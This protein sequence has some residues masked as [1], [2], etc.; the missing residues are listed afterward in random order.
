M[1][2]RYFLAEEPNKIYGRYH[3]SKNA[4]QSKLPFDPMYNIA[5]G[6]L[7]PIITGG[8]KH[9][10][11]IMKW[12]LIPYWA[13][14]PKIGSRLIN[15]RA[16]TINQKPS[17]K[18]SFQSKRCL[19]PA[20]GFY[21]WQKTGDEKIPHLIELKSKEIFSMAGIF[22]VWQD[23]EDKEFK[24]FS[25]VTTKSNDLLNKIHN[26][27]PVILEKDTEEKWLNINSNPESLL[28]LL[29]PFNSDLMH[30]YAISRK[31]NSPTNQGADLIEKVDYNSKQ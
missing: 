25:I 14:D 20:S 11:E 27:M 1:C 18:S 29:K 2:G 19:I 9:H 6:M 10:L 8:Q 13:K 30:T 12:G 17:F 7:V 3:L 22:D 4:P 31:V 21:E 23:A 15:A 26:R 28:N 16:E 5:P 24:T